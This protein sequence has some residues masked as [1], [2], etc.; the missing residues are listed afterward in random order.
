MSTPP[1][2][3][4]IFVYDEMVAQIVSE[5][6]DWHGMFTPYPFDGLIAWALWRD[7]GNSG[8]G[9]WI[10]RGNEYDSVREVIEWTLLHPTLVE[11]A[12]ESPVIHLPEDLLR[13][14]R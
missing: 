5:Q 11:P 10:V 13:P 1:K 12:G 3:S 8:L 9:P 4:M 6:G 14:R 2:T 7:F